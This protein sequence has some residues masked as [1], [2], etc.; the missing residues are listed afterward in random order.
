MSKFRVKALWVSGRD[1]K[2]FKSTEIVT[3]KDFPPGATEKLVRLN[4]LEPLENVVLETPGNI[5]V[6]G[7]ITIAIVSAVWKRPEVFA[8]FAEG[9]HILKKQNIVDIEV[10]ISGSEGEVSRTM[11]EKEGFRYI[12]CPNV[13]LATK[14][15]LPVLAARNL[16][17]DYV[18]CLGSD[19]IISPEL[20]K[21]YKS[22]MRKGI[23]YIGVTD[24]YFYDIASKRAA[25]WGGYREAYRK[26]ETAGAGRLISGRLMSLW[27]WAPWDIKHSKGLDRSMQL[28]L[29]T[30][31]HTKAVFSL[32]A[33]K[34]YAL[35]I[36]SGTNMT[37]FAL[38]DNTKFIPVNRIKK[39]FPYVC[40][41]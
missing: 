4:F 11:V 14:V 13:P 2:V 18:L 9:I 21:L 15:N 19:D 5:P 32:K 27:K 36:K 33:K 6:K 41:D 1:N 38:W 31:P 26:G 23:D 3:E 37:P 17:V 25:Y 10:I 24:F 29:R 22:Y 40:A 20:M 28:K 16:N 7:R 30:T 12:E 35:D 34:V 8:M 39:R